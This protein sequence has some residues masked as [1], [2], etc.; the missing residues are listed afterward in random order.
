MQKIIFLFL[1][2]SITSLTNAQKKLTF[3]GNVTDSLK[4]GIV[5]ANILIKNKANKIVH[6]TFTKDGGS[7]LFEM[8]DTAT[9]LII[10]VTAAG[11]E[12]NN[13]P[14]IL[15][16]QQYIFILKTLYTELQ[17]VT[18]KNSQK[19]KEKGDTLSYNV[20]SFAQKED[21]TIGDVI[22]RLPGI[23]VDDEGKISYNGKAIT[24]LIIHGDDLMN[25]RYG[26]A[27][28]AINKDDIKS[29]EVINHHQPINTLRKKINSNDVV[30]N[31]VLKDENRF[32]FSGQGQIG[33]GLPNLINSSASLIMLN[34]KI[35]MLNAAKYNNT[36]EDY[37]M[38][39]KN[40]S[41]NENQIPKTALLSDAVISNP[42]IP[43]IY[44]NRNKASF[45]SLN[46]LL[47]TKDTLQIRTN[48]FFNADRNALNYN[49]FTQNYTINDT[50]FFRETQEVLRKPYNLGTSLTFTKNK[51]TYYLKNHTQGYFNGYTNSSNLNFNGNIFGQ[52][53]KTIT[54][55]ITNNF[56]WIPN[57]LNKDVLV[58]NWTI[59]YLNLPQQ[60]NI[61]FGIDS[62]VLNNNKSYRELLQTAQTVMFN[63]KLSV[64]Y[65]INDK[66]FLKKSLQFRSESLYQRLT[67]EIELT[68]FDNTKNA[69][70]GDKGNNVKWTQSNYSIGANFWAKKEKWNFTVQI[71][72]TW[73]K[74]QFNQQVYSV[75]EKRPSFFV[76]PDI[77]GEYIFNQSNVIT[78]S[79]RFK[80]SFGGIQN[81]YKGIVAVNFRTLNNNEPFI[82][83]TSLN[84]LALR[85]NFKNN[86]SLFFFNAGMSYRRSD[87][88]AVQSVIYKDNIQ[89]IVFLPLNNSQDLITYNAGASKY[90]FSLKSKIS[91]GGS[92]STRNSNQFINNTFLPFQLNRITINAGADIKA[93]DFVNINYN[94]NA[95]FI[96]SKQSSQAVMTIASEVSIYNHSL[97][98]VVSPPKTNTNF[99]FKTNHQINKSNALPPAKFTF[100]DLNI[101]YASKKLRTD[102]EFDVNN[103]FNLTSYETFFNSINQL[104]YSSYQLRGAT[105]LLKATFNF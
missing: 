84:E 24:N 103:I 9:N 44:I 57:F 37:D 13:K 47:N 15:S 81:V 18:V 80:N 26:L 52:Q 54:T 91:L 33:M 50:I 28:K 100:C 38:L 12:K 93:V 4:V 2:A 23:S 68:Q 59:Q 16:Q 22:K 87:F 67:S 41:D 98:L 102:F 27:A 66:N 61:G 76:N 8:P 56:Q 99:T 35:K 42:G 78:A 36:G 1:F 63:N 69:F 72:F 29:V 94:I 14:L 55:D 49:Y 62:L 90:F 82:N 10:E 85:Y 75:N 92:Y 71:P 7:F 3:I 6:F 74:I 20:N 5:N 32:Q 77:K 64:E 53:I 97:A 34:K 25:G 58:F 45:F 30:V 48:V 11:F 51:T 39:N 86:L 43:N 83:E 104:V 70:T 88:N 105:A 95:N 17:Q 101:R 96:N 31:L 79:Y 40:L 73:Q 60:L 65:L 19:L 21:R 46:N 89:Q